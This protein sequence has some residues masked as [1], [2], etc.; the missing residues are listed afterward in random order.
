MKL[1]E[2]EAKLKECEE[3]NTKLAE[4]QSVYQE[5]LEREF[6][7]KT[8]D[9]LKQLLATTEAELEEKNAEYEKLV[10]TAEQLLKEAGVE[11]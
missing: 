9:Q 6:G 2:I 3:H 10:A 7:V 1:Q 11:C 5:S 8:T 4:R